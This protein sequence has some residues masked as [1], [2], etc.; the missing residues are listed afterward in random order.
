M[1]RI[2]PI[3]KIRR[4]ICLKSTSHTR[5]VKNCPLSIVH[6]Q[7]I[8]SS[9]KYAHQLTFRKRPVDTSI[10]LKILAVGLSGT[11]GALARFG[12]YGLC[13]HLGWTGFPW[14]TFLVNMLGCLAFGV[15]VS[16]AEHRF[17]FSEHTKL[18]VLVGFMGSFTTFST[19]AVDSSV[20]LREGA[21]GQAAVY[22]IGQNALGI[23]LIFLG[24]YAGRYVGVSNG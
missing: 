3:D 18:A 16:I 15:F 11:V 8:Q 22:L 19:F 5:T 10:A 13:R 12:V 21:F 7:L 9:L 24:L 23:A 17:P 2:G 14:A 6:C 4:P 20:M 1:R